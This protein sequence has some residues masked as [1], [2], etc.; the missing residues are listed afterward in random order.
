MA[1]TA[2][3]DPASVRIY[4]LPSTARAQ[5]L[6]ALQ[7]YGTGE[8]WDHLDIDWT[9]RRRDAWTPHAIE[10]LRAVGV[11]TIA[12]AA[13]ANVA[14]RPNAPVPLAG[15]V[16]EGFSD[17]L[18]GE[19]REP[20]VKVAG[21]QDTEAALEA[22][23]ATSETW[24]ALAEARDQIGRCGCAAILPVLEDGR[25]SAQVL[26]AANV[27][28]LEWEAKSAW[29]PRVVVEQKQVSVAVE[30]DGVRQM[31]PAWRTR[32]WDTERSYVFEDLLL[33]ESA[34]REHESE[35]D[36]QRR[37]NRVD[38]GLVLAPDGAQMHHAGRCPVIWMQNTR[39]SECPDS[40]PDYDQQSLELM[41][42]AD[43]LQS[44]LV[45]GSIAN[46]DPTLHVADY[47]WA[48]RFWPTREKGYGK[49]IQTSEAGQAKLIEIAGTSVDSSR[50]TLREIILQIEHRCGIVIID[51]DTAGSYR[52]GEAISLLWRRME[53]AA[54][55]KRRSLTRAVRQLAEIW[56][57]ILGGVGIKNVELP[58]RIIP[59]PDGKGEPTVQPQALGEGRWIKVEWPPYNY[60]TAA[61]LVS[62]AQ[63]LAV[64]TGG[65][66]ILS[67]ETATSWLLNTMG[68]TDAAREREQIDAEQQ[69]RV[70]ALDVE[71]EAG[72]DT[73]DEPEKPAAED[74]EQI[75]GAEG[76]P[77]GATV[78][79]T[80]LNGGQVKVLME[81][82]AAAGVTIAPESAIIMIANAFHVITEADARRMVEGQL[83]FVAANGGAAAPP[84]PAASPVV[85]QRAAD[86]ALDSGSEE[87]HDED[88]TDE[89]N[90]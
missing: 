48:Q 59:A 45:R 36:Y 54:G 53:Q 18:L 35:A 58:P 3:F 34:R 24:D 73:D 41:D 25:P 19:G 10:R 32:A 85:E 79:E 38:E 44:M 86:L 29:I 81:M 39:D 4:N 33:D 42:R 90:E 82:V 64:A 6:T 56:I 8:Q 88:E 5:L 13:Q 80:A 71:L 17:I 31:R 62:T 89:F 66:Q 75:E 16:V 40:S 22:V 37:R 60:P 15:L 47:V 27:M 30:V 21:D 67:A 28:V 52:S 49:V 63:A 78:Q 23:F 76:V 72:L 2:P 26:N 61:Q 9:G 65:K 50:T 69:A 55:R 74:G 51:P 84:T 83:A 11:W 46:V 68:R 70:D 77:T 14:R 1:E 43:V 7:R 12:A 87:D 57:T 20:A